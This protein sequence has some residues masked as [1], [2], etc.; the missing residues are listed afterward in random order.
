MIFRK[1]SQTEH[2]A[3]TLYPKIACT[4]RV[5]LFDAS[6]HPFLRTPLQ[7][8][9]SPSEFTKI[10]FGE[11]IIW[12]VIIWALS[13]MNRHLFPSPLEKLML[14]STFPTVTQH[15]A[16][17]NSCPSTW[18]SARSKPEAYSPTVGWLASRRKVLLWE[19]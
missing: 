8:E 15:R 16:S 6:K 19:V 3:V 12:F 10:D 17:V 14:S 5:L 18:C 9:A 4:P 2:K 13:G 7:A 11:I 1:W